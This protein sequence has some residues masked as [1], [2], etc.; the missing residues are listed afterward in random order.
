[1]KIPIGRLPIFQNSKQFL[2][3]FRIKYNQPNPDFWI[4]VAVGA[5]IANLFWLQKYFIWKPFEH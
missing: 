3:S 1:M 5:N 2:S 4:G